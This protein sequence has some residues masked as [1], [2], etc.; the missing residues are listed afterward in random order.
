MPI[1]YMISGAVFAL[2]HLNLSVIVPFALIGV[3]FAWA[4]W[5]SG[6]LWTTIGA[7]AAVNGLSFAFAV[8]GT[9]P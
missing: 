4:F 2:F 7:H 3:I 1:A 5:N 8:A 9:V 6:S